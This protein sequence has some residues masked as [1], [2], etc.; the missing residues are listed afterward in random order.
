MADDSMGPNGQLVT[1]GPS[2]DRVKQAHVNS[3]LGVQHDFSDVCRLQS[4]VG[5]GGATYT[6]QP[7]HKLPCR[8]GNLGLGVR[9]QSGGGPAVA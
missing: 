1:P 7:G 9:Q 8:S 4:Y 6:V 3:L 5:G 2:N